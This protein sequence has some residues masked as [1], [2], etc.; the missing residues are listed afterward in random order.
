MS[1][2]TPVDLVTRI[3]ADLKQAMRDRDE[4][5]KLTLRSV[6]T[7]LTEARTSGDSWA[8]PGFC[9][10]SLDLCFSRAPVAGSGGA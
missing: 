4:V 6:K 7:A 5:K 1:E 2:T 10:R 9:G 8:S 3:D